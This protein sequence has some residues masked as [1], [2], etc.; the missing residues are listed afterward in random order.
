M[1]N[2]T[3]GKVTVAL[4]A[5]SMGIDLAKPGEDRT[6]YLDTATGKDLDNLAKTMGIKRQIPEEHDADYKG[7]LKG[8]VPLDFKGTKLEDQK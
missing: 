2:T 1:L 6:V 8:T 5:Y 7:P 4:P 3:K